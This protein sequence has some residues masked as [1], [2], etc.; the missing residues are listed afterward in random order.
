[1]RRGLLAFAGDLFLLVFA[2]FLA[3]MFRLQFGGIAWS[4]HE[5]GLSVI[6]VVSLQ[7]FCLWA[8]G[9]RRI[10]WRYITAQDTIRFGLAL[11]CAAVLAA[12][13]RQQ[14]PSSASLPL[15]YAI[16]IL[17]MLL[18]GGFLVGARLLVRL[19][20]E[21]A[22]WFKQTG[23]VKR[24]LLVG[25]MSADNPV[26]RELRR[27]RDVRFQTVGLLDDAP[28]NQRAIIQGVPVLGKITT[29]SKWVKRLRVD[30]IIISSG[31]LSR[32]EI[33][34]LTQLAE[35]LQKPIRIVPSLPD[36]ISG[37][38][39]VECLR[40]IDI[41][42]LLGRVE[43]PLDSEA[44][45]GYFKGKR[46]WVTGAGGSI[47]SELVRQV[48][49]AQP[50]ALILI[51]RSE[52]ALYEIDR[53]IRR[54]FP[55][56]PIVS[57]LADV[58]DESHMRQLLAQHPP[59]VILHAA[60][61]K[62]VPMVERN[63]GEG[64]VNNLLATRT[65]A[66]LAESAGV[67]VFLLISTDKAINP[68]SVMGI[69]KRLA[70]IAVR[71]LQGRSATRFC[72]VRFGNV[73]GSSGSVIPLFKEQIEQGGPITITHPEM[74]RYFM[75]VREAAR[76]VL[77]AATLAKGGEIF[78]LDMGEPVK[79]A[80]MAEEMIRLSGLRPHEDIEIKF[81]GIR[82]GEKLFEELDIADAEQ[83]RHPQIYIGR[84][85][86][87]PAGEVAAMLEAAATLAGENDARQVIAA[88]KPWL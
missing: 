43:N 29:L 52:T 48:A 87:R 11:F 1:M 55:E 36:L 60:A 73:L 6:V 22:L 20:D 82:P 30:E 81:T 4:F 86:Q 14:L 61:Y 38:E 24:V 40:N 49:H 51:E 13:L 63:P 28:K 27:Q 84:I 83:T 37:K 54:C 39:K 85:P 78:V 31:A 46:V 3:H 9:T 33:R 25:A 57:I 74:Q 17:D 44:V 35:K 47:G 58:G 68:V 12:I 10:P 70:E 8:A 67:E 72:A 64:V 32:Q 62:H 66:Q 75:T 34:G 76:L 26:L 41:S 42:D 18:A 88:L 19:F 2:Y 56:L 53:E 5:S 21:G 69:T 79:I 77:Q 59:A 7:L 80:D 15:S 65:L 50:D 16:I 45:T 71:D 23:S